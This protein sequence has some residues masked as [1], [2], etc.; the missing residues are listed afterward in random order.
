MGG[1]K[2]L[3]A[4]QY[5]SIAS[6]LTQVHGSIATHDTDREE[7]RDENNGSDGN[8]LYNLQNLISRAPA[9]FRKNLYL[10]VGL[11]VRRARHFLWDVSAHARALQ[12]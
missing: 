8:Q 6:R 5:M 10:A 2:R 1:Y 12:K 3:Q 7:E 11:T 4:S 9:L